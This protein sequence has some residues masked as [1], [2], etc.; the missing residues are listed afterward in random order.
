M[1]PADY[2]LRGVEFRKIPSWVAGLDRLTL[3]GAFAMVGGMCAQERTRSTAM[4]C[5]LAAWFRHDR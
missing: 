1:P 2:I 3:C 5:P 4:A